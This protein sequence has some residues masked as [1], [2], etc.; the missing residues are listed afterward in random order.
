MIRPIVGVSP[1][2]TASRRLAV[3]RGFVLIPAAAAILLSGCI[4]VGPDYAPPPAPVAETWIDTEEGKQI[5]G[6]PTDDQE[7]W[8]VS[9]DPVLDSLVETAYRQNPTQQRLKAA[10]KAS[11]PSPS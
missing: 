9:G 5:Q 3:H 6:E 4:M 8:K 11:R 2:P 7:W 10:K 1:A